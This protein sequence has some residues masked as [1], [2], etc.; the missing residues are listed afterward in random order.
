MSN[1]NKLNDEELEKV[2]GGTEKSAPKYVENERVFFKS[3]YNADGNSI[4]FVGSGIIQT[5]YEK[6]EGN[7]YSISHG[8]INILYGK[9]CYRVT[10]GTSYVPEKFVNHTGNF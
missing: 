8:L 3:S 9:K 1:T 6:N 5:V 2:T 10:E 4:S 7:F